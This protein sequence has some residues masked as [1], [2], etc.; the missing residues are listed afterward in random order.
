MKPLLTLFSFLL[1]GCTKAQV[2]G[3]IT[4]SSTSSTTQK[5]LIIFTGE[6][7]SGG[8]APNSSATSG[9]LAPRSEVQIWHN[10]NNNFTNLDIGT[11]NLLGHKDLDPEKATVSHGWE[12][13]LANRVSDGDL[14]NPVYLV[15][16]GQG[17]TRIAH[18]AEGAT[19]STVNPWAK[20]QARVDSAITYLTAT[21]GQA[22]RL[23]IFYSQGINDMNAATAT[24]TW[25]AA[26]KAH[27]QKIRAKYGSTVPI[28]M[29]K[30]YIS[31]YT[32]Y[33]T[34]IDEIA[35]EEP[36]TYAVSTSGATSGSNIVHWD[37]AGMK[38]VANNLINTMLTN[39][40]Y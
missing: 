12:L 18:W 34:A 8:D 9:E 40:P 35:A 15:K 39:Y 31:G 1:L 5:T 36:Y 20:F 25:K 23:F 2:L 13:Q 11:N 37:Y 26:T 24:A 7:N 28:F 27:L 32:T 19:Y 30:I 33:N 4:N 6:S 17:S 10:Y 21:Y 29:T 38:L 16:T 22:P 3:V 14:P